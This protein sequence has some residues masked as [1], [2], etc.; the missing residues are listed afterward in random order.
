M[1][2]PDLRCL[3][4]ALFTLAVAGCGSRSEPTPVAVAHDDDIPSASLA[5]PSV[6]TIAVEDPAASTGISSLPVVIRLDDRPEG[7]WA[8]KSSEIANA[9]AG[10]AT[11]AVTAE[12]ESAP[13]QQ[14]PAA[15][16]QAAQKPAPTWRTVDAG[17]LEVPH[18]IRPGRL[19]MNR[20]VAK[21]ADAEPQLDFPYAAT[22]ECYLLKVPMTYAAA[23]DFDKPLTRVDVTFVLGDVRDEMADASPGTAPVQAQPEAKKKRRIDGMWQ[24]HDIKDIGFNG[25]RFGPDP[26]PDGPEQHYFLSERLLGRLN[27]TRTLRRAYW[28][29]VANSARRIPGEITAHALLVVPKKAIGGIGTMQMKLWFT[30]GD[31]ATVVLPAHTIDISFAPLVE[32]PVAQGK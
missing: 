1:R 24:I 26:M 8:V 18:A 13:A 17:A 32:K 29:F 7:F 23:A 28:S 9:A 6:A 5:K 2:A 22:H 15:D 3:S 11:Y 12:P 14:T 25:L 20:A 19:V 31:E 10:N 4:I 27:D 16:G 30:P 21:G